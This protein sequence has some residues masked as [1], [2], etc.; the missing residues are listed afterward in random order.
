MKN[1]NANVKKIK[2]DVKNIKNETISAP[3]EKLDNQIDDIVAEKKVT[4]LHSKLDEII[5]KNAKKDTKVPEHTIRDLTKE[6]SILDEIS[7]QEKCKIMEDAM[8]LNNANNTLNLYFVE[9]SKKFN[10]TV[11]RMEKDSLEKENKDNILPYEYLK[12]IIE[13][14]NDR[15]AFKEILL[16]SKTRP[17]YITIGDYDFFF[18][19]FDE[20]QTPIFKFNSD[21]FLFFF[22]SS[23]DA[24]LE[25]IKK[26]KILYNKKVSFDSLKI[27]LLTKEETIKKEAKEET[28]KKE[29]KEETIKKEAKEETIKE[30]AKKKEIEIATKR[31]YKVK[32]R[33]YKKLL[34]SINNPS[35]IYERYG[36]KNILS[37][38][39]IGKGI[40]L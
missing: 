9:Q 33:N 3:D 24:L 21:S 28:I 7:S 12:L 8:W 16:T 34:I 32:I 29:A 17:I 20:E 4:D 23:S 40:N 11:E 2:K 37:I 30:E 38:K 1:V 26:N 10:D 25:Y 13:N 35:E 19:Y 14:Q 31:V 5:N 36:I 15:I 39:Y 27:E 22:N 6:K 18:E